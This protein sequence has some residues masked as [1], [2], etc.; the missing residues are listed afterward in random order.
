MYK[1]VC[2]KCNKN[3]NIKGTSKLIKVL[4]AC[5]Y[6]GCNDYNYTEYGMLLNNR[7]SKIEKLKN[8]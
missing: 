3:F 6:C 2:L 7:L 8:E 5:P 1:F 4:C